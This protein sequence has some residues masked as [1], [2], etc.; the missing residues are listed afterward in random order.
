MTRIIFWYGMKYEDRNHAYSFV[1]ED[2]IVPFKEGQRLGYCQMLNSMQKQLEKKQELTET[3]ERIKR[4]LIEFKADMARDKDDR[5][6]WMTRL[7]AEDV[8]R[9]GG[10]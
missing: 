3:E 9:T 4:G 7:G 6:A 2:A 10:D 8:I 5:V 1:P